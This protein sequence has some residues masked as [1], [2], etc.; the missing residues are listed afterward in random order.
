M[1]NHDDCD[2]CETCVDMCPIEVLNLGEDDTG[3]RIM[4]D[5]DFCIGCGVCAANC[6]N[7]A[8]SL[9]KTSK[10]IPVETRPGLFGE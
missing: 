8:I 2:L 6:P 5:R 3:E 4:I 9:N 10:N 1:I 7:E